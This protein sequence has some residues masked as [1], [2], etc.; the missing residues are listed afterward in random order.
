M[1]LEDKYLLLLNI[2]LILLGISLQISFCEYHCA[3]LGHKTQKTGW[4][5]QKADAGFLSTPVRF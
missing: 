3:K 5:T 4:R 1:T 2:I